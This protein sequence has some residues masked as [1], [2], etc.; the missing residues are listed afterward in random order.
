MYIHYGWTDPFLW[1]IIIKEDIPH[2]NNGNDCGVF[3]VV[4][5]KH[6]VHRCPITF[7]QANISY[8]HS[9]IDIELFKRSWQVNANRLNL[10]ELLN[11]PR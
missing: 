6:C 11:L 7:M 1:T 8:F 9:R 4:F 10:P 3:V 5:A 2:Q